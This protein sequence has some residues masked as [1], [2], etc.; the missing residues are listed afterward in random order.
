M[1][2]N[3]EHEDEVKKFQHQIMVA[4]ITEDLRVNMEPLNLRKSDLLFVKVPLEI[5]TD[6]FMASL[7]DQFQAIFPHYDVIM[8]PQV[9]IKS[10]TMEDIIELRD[11]LNKA[12]EVRENGETK[13]DI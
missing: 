9:D 1:N 12:L 7:F 4:S 5:C 10:M 11:N 6:E 2:Y 13:A 3:Y 8:T